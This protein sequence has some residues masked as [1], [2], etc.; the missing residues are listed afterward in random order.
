MDASAYHLSYQQFCDRQRLVITANK[1][2][3]DWRNL[4]VLR[5]HF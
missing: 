4:L 5:G 1:H 3:V 2:W